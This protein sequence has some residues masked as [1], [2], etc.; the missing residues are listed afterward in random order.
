M[1]NTVS[2]FDDDLLSDK[3]L[4]DAISEI[5]EIA[6]QAR[7]AVQQGDALPRQAAALASSDVQD[8]ASSDEPQEGSEKSEE[9]ERESRRETLRNRAKRQRSRGRRELGRTFTGALSVETDLKLNDQAIASH[10]ERFFGLIDNTL[11]LIARRGAVILGP[12]K[13]EKLMDKVEELIDEYASTASTSLRSS[14]AL[15]VDG[16]KANFDWIVPK[17][18]KEALAIQVHVKTRLGLKIVSAFKEWDQVVHNLSVLAWNEMGSDSQVDEARRVERNAIGAIFRFIL[19]IVIGIQRS[20][21]ANPRR[22][23]TKEV[24][25]EGTADNAAS[26]IGVKK[27]EEVV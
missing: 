11:Y 15:L 1:T 23:Q 13:S 6:A 26:D 5:D 16:E 19:E 25:D 8:K 20:T 9:E 3:H 2:Q 17:Y 22:T 12:D 7:I 21:Q 18:Q 4:N 14:T 10:F 24:D 27:I